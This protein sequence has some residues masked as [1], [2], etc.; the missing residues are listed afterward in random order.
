MDYEGQGQQCCNSEFNEILKD[1]GELRNGVVHVSNN[2]F[3]YISYHTK[4][5]FY[6]TDCYEI[7]KVRYNNKIKYLKSFDF[8]FH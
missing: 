6:I 5:T 1:N 2:L 7:M 8:F 4:C 3:S